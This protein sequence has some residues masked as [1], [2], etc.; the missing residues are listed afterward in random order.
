MLITIEL[1]KLLNFEKEQEK[2]IK[3]CEENRKLKDQIASYNNELCKLK[4]QSHAQNEIERFQQSEG[5]QK[6]D[7]QEDSK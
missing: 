1:P 4:S 6:V 2:F 7:I 5:N 3:L